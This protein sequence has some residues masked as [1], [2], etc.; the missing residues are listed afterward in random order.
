[1]DGN[2][3][4]TRLI[5]ARD[6]LCKHP[7]DPRPEARHDDPREMLWLLNNRTDFTGGGWRLL[8]GRENLKVDVVD[9]ANHY[10]VM[11]SPHAVGRHRGVLQYKLLELHVKY[12]HAV[13][14]A[15][16]EMSFTSENAWKTIYG[17]R[18]VEMPKDPIFS[19]LTPTG[20][21]NIMLHV[22][23]FLEQ[24][25]NNSAAGPVNMVA[26]A[27]LL[28]FDMVG[29]MAFG[30]NFGCL[31]RGDYDP[32]VRAIQ[33]MATELTYTQMWKYWRL[34]ALPK[35]LMSK[36]VVGKRVENVKR[37][38]AAVGRRLQRET[39]RKDFMHYI[40]AA[41][42]EKGM[43]PQ[44][45]HVNAFSLNIA[46]SDYERLMAE[47]TAAFGSETDI[48]I[49]STHNLEFMDAV[50]NES[51]RLYPPVAITMPR[52]T[53]L[54]GETIDGIYVP[55]GMTVGVHHFSC[56][57]HPENFY[58][59]ND[60]LPERFLAANRDL[61]PFQ[62]DNRACLQ[63][64]SFGPRGCLGKNLA[65]AEM[66][67]ALAKL[68]FRFAVKLQPGQEE[69]QRSQRLQGFWKKPP[70]YCVLLPKNTA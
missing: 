54:G 63:P 3:P 34:Q 59:S 56:Y 20:V 37:A 30:E 50:I 4:S 53:P 29:D 25:S 69:W 67:L 43:S 68:L 9:D 16:N 44:E 33:S 23:K 58:R 61:A 38:M 47:I 28:T 39:S 32:F 8:V 40:L 66:R 62:E 36:E 7:D 55:G 19:L 10:T 49:A 51:L 5:Y 31:D 14:V 11:S 41:N 35:Y 52:R 12:G 2:A 45:I 24:L 18:S 46:G 17:Q 22:S 70:L 21:Q 6:G 57:R 27:N 60:F 42:D 13:R 64:F 1:F 48:T 26:W 15:P 65:R